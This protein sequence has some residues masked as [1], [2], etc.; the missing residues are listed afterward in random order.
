MAEDR[1]SADV[2]RLVAEH[3]RAVYSYAFRLTASAADAEDLTQQV[4]LIAQEKLHQ[5]RQ[6]A[7]ARKWLFTILRNQFLRVWQRQRPILATSLGLDLELVPAPE[8]KVRR[9]DPTGLQQ[10]IDALGAEHRVV[11]AMFYFEECSYREIAEQL[12]LPIGTVMSRLARAKR[13]LRSALLVS[14]EPVGPERGQTTPWSMS[15]AKTI[16]HGIR[17]MTS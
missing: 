15:R 11:L 7:S 17:R 6:V 5:L 14:E 8:E 10:A 16:P 9:V 3:Q 13:T 2:Q 1:V 4:F 12:G